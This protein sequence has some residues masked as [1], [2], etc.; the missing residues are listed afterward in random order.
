MERRENN[1]AGNARGR[2]TFIGLN[3]QFY[4]QRLSNV[5]LFC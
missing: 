3:A 2:G 1:M 4:K 5:D